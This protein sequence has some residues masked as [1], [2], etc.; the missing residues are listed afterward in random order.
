MK[1]VAITLTMMVFLL[2]SAG[3]SLSGQQAVDDQQKQ[4][5]EKWMKFATPGEPH[6]F[7]EKQVGEWEMVSKMWM[8]PGDPP[9]ESKGSAS[10]KM[11]LGGRY[12]KT[13]HKGFVSG[14]PFEG[15]NIGGYDNHLKEYFSIWIDN[16]GTGI[17]FSKG[18][19]DKTGKILTEVAEIDDFMTGQKMKARSVTTCINAD[20]LFMEMYMIGP[21]G[22]E[23]KS[24]EVTYIR[25]K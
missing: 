22:K 20:K 10:G 13:V 17:M 19:L 12:L 25:K 9:S 4:M 7:L 6:K 21:D 2:G 15:I 11:I 18:N 24:V 8:K 1:N 16:M 3:F 14:M 23:F 5:M